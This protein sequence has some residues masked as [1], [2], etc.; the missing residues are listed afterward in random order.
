MLKKKLLFSHG[1]QRSHDHSTG[2]C[3]CSPPHR[4]CTTNAAFSPCSAFWIRRCTHWMIWSPSRNAFR[5]RHRVAEV[6]SALQLD[7]P[8]LFMQQAVENVAELAPDDRHLTGLARELA[9][10]LEEDPVTDDPRRNRLVTQLRSHI[11][12][13]WRLHRR[14]LRMRRSKDTQVLLP[15]RDGAV[16]H[17][18]DCPDHGLLDEAFHEWRVTIAQGAPE[19]PAS[20]AREQLVRVIAEAIV[21]DPSIVP[22]LVSARLDKVVDLDGLA[23]FPDE[24]Q[25]I[26]GVPIIDGE[27]KLLTRLSHLAANLEPTFG[28]S[29]VPCFTLLRRNWLVGPKTAFRSFCLPITRRRPT[30]CSECCR[31]DLDHSRSSDIP[32]H[33]PTG[34]RR[35]P[36]LAV[37]YL[38]VTAVR[39][40]V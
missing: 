38:S 8:N 24:L 40:K 35:C 10:Y 32:R 18:W 20:V 6:L 14:I 23:L 27:S 22:L 13:T 37:A 1:L 30:N 12:E 36:E 16:A 19:P 15:Q 31:S 3:C 34:C 2:S 5:Q 39:K 33:P 7:E 21:C 25:A 11:S 9:D 4:L 26:R 28:S 29:P 17:L